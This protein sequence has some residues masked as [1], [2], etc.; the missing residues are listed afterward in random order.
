MR[1]CLL[2][3][4]FRANPLKV[5]YLFS[6]DSTVSSGCMIANEFR[7]KTSEESDELLER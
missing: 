5:F 4:I 3:S 6:G 7:D 2:C 1:F